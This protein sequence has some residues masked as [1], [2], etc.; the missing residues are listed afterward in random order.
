VHIASLGFGV[1]LKCV[2]VNVMNF[3]G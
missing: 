1:C 2:I 3:R